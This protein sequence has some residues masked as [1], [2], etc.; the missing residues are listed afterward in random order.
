MKKYFIILTVAALLT[1]TAAIFRSPMT[2]SLM[3]KN[4]ND[5][6]NIQENQA[7]KSCLHENRHLKKWPK[8]ISDFTPIKSEKLIL[9]SQG[10]S[11]IKT[12][13]KND[14]LTGGVTE[15]ASGVI[16]ERHGILYE[17]TGQKPKPDTI[18]EHK[19]IEDFIDESKEKTKRSAD[20]L[21]SENEKIKEDAEKIYH[22]GESLMETTGEKIKEG[23]HSAGE[24]A[25]K[26]MENVKEGVKA[27]G[28]AV[29][30]GAEK[31][32]HA[33]HDTTEAAGT[34]IKHGLETVREDGE[35]IL[36]S[37][38]EH[39]KHDAKHLHDM[40]EKVLDS[41]GATVKHG[42]EKAGEVIKHGAEKTG[43]AVKHG[44]EK[45]KKEGEK[46]LDAAGAN[47]K[48]DAKI[49]E[50]AA[51]TGAEKAYETGEKIMDAA[52]A[53]VKKGA[54]TAGE[55]VKH[56]A[57]F[58]YE[59]GGKVISA[60]AGVLG[61]GAEAAGKAIKNGAE[62]LYD[63]GE[64][65]VDAAG[66][67]VKKGAE[68]AGEA[69]KHSAEFIGEKAKNAVHGLKNDDE[70]K[71]EQT[72][73]DT[74]NAK[75]AIHKEK[76]EPAPLED[77]KNVQNAADDLE[78]KHGTPKTDHASTAHN[79]KLH[80][81]NNSMKP[82]PQQKAPIIIEETEIMGILEETPTVND[83]TPPAAQNGTSGADSE[84]DG[85]DGDDDENGDD[86]EEDDMPGSV[87]EKKDGIINAKDNHIKKADKNTVNESEDNNDDNNIPKNTH[88][89]ENDVEMDA[90]E[91]QDMQQWIQKFASL[92]RTHL[93]DN[94][95]QLPEDLLVPLMDEGF[96]FTEMDGQPV[97]VM[98]CSCT[99]TQFGNIISEDTQRY[100]TKKGIT[101][102]IKSML[103]H[104]YIGTLVTQLPETVRV[105][106]RIPEEVGLWVEYVLPES[107]AA[108]AG[109]VRGDI[110]L[111]AYVTDET[112]TR[113]EFQLS[114][115]EELS[116]FITEM[117]EKPFELLLVC[118]GRQKY[119]KL[120][121]VKNTEHQHE[122]LNDSTTGETPENT[123][124]KTSG[125]TPENTP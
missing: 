114:S 39:I 121:A 17:D 8:N 64:K 41:A 101:R 11:G 7:T 59:E 54:E 116:N 93:M 34:A 10:M 13:I 18:K 45:A 100:I 96:Y 30:H 120:S 71:S 48:K 23:V 105:H 86:D 50:E 52:G 83:N 58:I 51:K 16:S 33:I 81:E 84:D 38:G 61:T 68:T 97:I 91:I 3:T 49:V 37:A 31:L 56:S 44:A 60:A 112:G 2:S 90:E 46:I 94:E 122:I 65:A 63:A 104:F 106:Y 72:S 88:E 62:K 40:N 12:E 98:Q 20:M 113:H 73:K 14:P 119:I 47:L 21:R 4:C 82:D 75:D 79:E 27:A 117:Q 109:I 53:A 85:E 55:A 125:E 1:L 22:K 36:D 69:V 103:P 102:T 80:S 5:S 6:K 76:I 25:Q 26:G 107:P 115:Q 70:K 78:K 89:T 32:G 74:E 35:K 77:K 24:M 99:E 28:A 118:S 110:L 29:K 124:S 42:A 43:E 67:T 66:A 9:R 95:G 57:E 87:S 92:V 111:A 108:K 19:G 15:D 123:P